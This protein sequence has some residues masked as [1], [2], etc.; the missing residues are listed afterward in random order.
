MKESFDGEM[1]GLVI[2]AKERG[3]IAERA[4]GSG[5]IIKPKAAKNREETDKILS[6]ILVSLGFLPNLSGTA[7]LREAVKIE[8]QKQRKGKSKMKDLYPL[9]AKEFFTTAERVE[10]SIRNALEVAWNRSGEKSFNSVFGSSVFG[11]YTR[12][13]SSELIGLLADKINF[14]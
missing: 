5:I 8:L 9:V 4:A 6:A 3:Y 14:G 1:E 13:T 7:Y 2:L 12:P 11:R 10:R